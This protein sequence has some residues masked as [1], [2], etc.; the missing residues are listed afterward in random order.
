MFKSAV[1]NVQLGFNN[2]FM[3]GFNNVILNVD[4]KL[5]VLKSAY[6]SI[7]DSSLCVAIIKQ[8]N[9]HTIRKLQ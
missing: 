5:V 6:L 1:T 2:I 9:P 4:N 8:P 3:H 7:Y